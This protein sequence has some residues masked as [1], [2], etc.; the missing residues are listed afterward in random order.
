M[1]ELII[2]PPI[3]AGL[4]SFLFQKHPRVSEIA[5]VGGAALAAFFAFFSLWSFLQAPGAIVDFYGFLYMDSV[6]AVFTSLTVVVAFFVFIYSIGY[7]RHEVEEKIVAESQLGTYYGLLS[8]FLASMLTATL[9]SNI[10]VMWA[11]IEATTLAT[12]FLISFYNT[13]NSI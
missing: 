13:S 8:F 7:I 6:S 4:L 3:I 12:V 2:I 5:A 9:A 1:L 10:I 11:A